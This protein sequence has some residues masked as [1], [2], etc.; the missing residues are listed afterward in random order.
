MTKWQAI[1][2]C[3]WSEAPNADLV[4]DEIADVFDAYTDGKL[5]PRDQAPITSDVVGQLFEQGRRTY[6]VV[7]DTNRKVLQLVN[8]SAR[9]EQR[10][11]DVIPRKEPSDKNKRIYQHTVAKRFGG[12][13]PCGC[14]QQIIDD[15][16]NVLL[17]QYGPLLVYDHWYTRERNGIRTYVARSSHMQRPT[18]G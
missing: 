10:M 1:K 9:I 3:M 8:T 15:N 18:E 13:C 4:Q 14:R 12:L 6:E 16:G 2:I 7:E 11:N 5:V 17:D